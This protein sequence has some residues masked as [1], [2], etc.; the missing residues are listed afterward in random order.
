MKNLDTKSIQDTVT[1]KSTASLQWLKTQVDPLRD[2]INKC[3]SGTK[4]TGLI[5]F[6]ILTAS[7]SLLLII[8]AISGTTLTS[9]SID[10]ITN[11]IEKY[12]TPTDTTELIPI[13]KL[14][15]ERNGD[16]E[17]FYVAKDQGGN[18]Y[19][20]HNPPYTQE[21]NT[22]SKDWSPITAEQFEMLKQELH[23]IPTKAK[24]LRP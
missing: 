18:L 1:K 12:M 10:F 16:F 21:R 9:I 19:I 5:L 8:R 2:R 23:F 13:G 11:P 3:S 15:G 20:N 24:S 17:A 14:K 4:K 22:K 6:G 7:I